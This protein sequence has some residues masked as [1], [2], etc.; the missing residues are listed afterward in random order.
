MSNY[1]IDSLVDAL[2]RNLFSADEFDRMFRKLSAKD[3]MALLER[4]DMAAE[5][6]SGKRTH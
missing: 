6:Q 3:R 1:Q 4:L 2:T 5:A